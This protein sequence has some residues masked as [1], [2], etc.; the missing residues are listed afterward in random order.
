M[1]HLR[2]QLSNKGTPDKKFDLGLLF[3]S[4]RWQ[5]Q[6]RNMNNEH[7]QFNNERKK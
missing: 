5:Y 7:T 3:M 4:A 2:T 1:G 6:I